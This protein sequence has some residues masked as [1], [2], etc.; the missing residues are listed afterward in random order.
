MGEAIENDTDLMTEVQSFWIEPA[1]HIQLLDDI[2]ISMIA[3]GVVQW[4]QV[5]PIFLKL[6]LTSPSNWSSMTAFLIFR[7]FVTRQTK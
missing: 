1:L 2:Q 5:R 7:S 3:A 6:S 4:L